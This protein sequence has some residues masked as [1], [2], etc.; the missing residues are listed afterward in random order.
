MLADLIGL[1]LLMAFVAGLVARMRGKKRENPV[2]VRTL[3]EGVPLSK[4]PPRLYDSD[5]SITELE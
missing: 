3:A 2:G 5:P 1:W 4:E